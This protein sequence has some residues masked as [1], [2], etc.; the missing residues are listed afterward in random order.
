MCS[1]IYVSLLFLLIANCYSAALALEIMA[2]VVAIVNFQD[3][4]I[5]RP[6]SIQI[7]ILS[8][9]LFDIVL[10]ARREI[11]DLFKLL[12]VAKK[13]PRE[14][15]HVEPHIA[16]PAHLPHGKIEVKSVDINDCFT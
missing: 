7:E 14:L 4:L 11:L 6:Q 1:D 5:E 16:R 2:L 8:P 10:D 9:L 13:L 15:N 12:I 3:V